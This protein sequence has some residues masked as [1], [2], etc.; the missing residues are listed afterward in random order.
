MLDID[1]FVTAF[2]KLAAGASRIVVAVSGGG[3][4]VCMLLLFHEAINQGLLDIDVTVITFNH[5]L[6]QEAAEEASY[7]QSLA[8]QWK[9][10]HVILEWEGHKP[11][12]NLQAQARDKRY[13]RICEWCQDNHVEFV[14]VAHHKNDQA[15]TIFMNIARGSGLD[16]LC[17]IVRKRNLYGVNII[18]PMM[19]FCKEE[20]LNYLRS[21]QIKWIEDPSNNNQK[22]TRSLYRSF[23]DVHSN[24][25]KLTDRLSGLSIH[26]SKVKDALDFYVKKECLRVVRFCNSGHLIIDLK[27]LLQL[28]REVVERIIIICLC[29]LGGGLYKPRLSSFNRLLASILSAETGL[30]ST[31]NGCIILVEGNSLFIIRESSK[32]NDVVQIIKESCTE[33]DRRFH[34][35]ISIDNS[36]EYSLCSLGHDG[37]CQ[38]LQKDRNLKKLKMNREI[39]YSLPCLK[40]GVIVV[41]CPYLEYYIRNVSFD[42]RISNELVEGFRSSDEEVGG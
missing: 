42:F 23:L 9:F 16:G 17:G 3:D 28:P 20:I 2:N 39:I 30:K 36:K 33:W 35:N 18:R 15:E 10:K 24:N 37:W 1:S 6:R 13:R 26:M 14:A 41:S 34:C 4:S 12:S 31:M 22:Y 5:G 27:L 11:S 32:I 38:L 40:E 25:N 7:V 29:R 8:T 19:D 21:R